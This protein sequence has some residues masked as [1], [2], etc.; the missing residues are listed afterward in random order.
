MGNICVRAGR[1]AYEEIL[2]GG[3]SLDRIGTYFG[4]AGG[5]RWLVASGFDLTFLKEGL[6]GRTF[7]IWLV[8]ASAGAWRFAAW[9]Q[10][11]AV[12]SYLA[13]MEAY[14]SATY[15]KK[16]TPGMILQSLNAII[17]SYIEDDALP[18]ALTNKKYRL[19]VLTC[20]MKHLTASERP[21]V[22]KAGF[23]LGFLINALH[24]SLI[25]LFAERVVFYNGSRPPEFCLR[26][27]FRGCFIPLSEVN[28]KSAVIASGAIPIA[29]GGVRDIYGAPDGIYRDGGFLDYHINQ[30]FTTQNNGL[31]LFFHH[32]ERIIPGWMDKRL[33]RRRPPES[34]LDS[35]IMIHPSETF[36]AGLPGSRV[37]DRG[38]FATF[39]N[40]PAVRIANWRRAVDLA[41]PLG[42]EF[43]E[44]I[45]S[46]R[47]KNVVEKL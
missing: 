26:K 38:D 16:D 39:I 32:Q 29:V 28:F 22:Q 33:K 27:E 18:F 45:A 41:A 36:I 10:P 3:F 17:D 34:A 44:M 23:V 25:H 46:G 37:P 2:A 9:L 24:P 30:D 35:V 5:P 4:P 7:P 1:R 47:L 19:A 21:W 12:K 15:G 43:L 40:D 8:G 11:E 14:I 31:T 20:R 13:L 6:L 42:E